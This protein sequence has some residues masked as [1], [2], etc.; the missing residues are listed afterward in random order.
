M[1]G[2]QGTVA[3]QDDWVDTQRLEDEAVIA[4]RSAAIA[5]Q[6]GDRLERYL[7]EQSSPNRELVAMIKE[8]DR[9]AQRWRKR[10]AELRAQADKTKSQLIG[11]S[12]ATM[13]QDTERM[14]IRA[15]ANTAT[16]EAAA[17]KYSKLQ[18]D[19]K[20]AGGY[21]KGQEINDHA[22]A[23]YQQTIVAAFMPFIDKFDF[24]GDT[25]EDRAAAIGQA[26]L[27]L[28]NAG[29]EQERLLAEQQFAGMLAIASGIKR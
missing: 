12:I 3:K 23:Q 5:E 26:A 9:A 25:L 28:A 20:V 10:S 14:K 29:N 11:Q 13:E 27:M 24:L 7:N 17:D 16:E 1:G 15:E 22:I 21:L 4:E 6:R 2:L 18:E 19:I 8:N